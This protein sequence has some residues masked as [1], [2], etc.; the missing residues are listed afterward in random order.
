MNEWL[1]IAKDMESVVYPPGSEKENVGHHDPFPI[2][3][4]DIPGPQ[5]HNENKNDRSISPRPRPKS[6][7]ATSPR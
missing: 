7:H 6:P 4:H 2:N 1:K 5:P 3:S